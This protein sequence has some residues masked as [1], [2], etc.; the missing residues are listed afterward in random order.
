MPAYSA[1]ML[2]AAVWPAG[3]VFDGGKGLRHDLAEGFALGDAG[4]EFTG[5]GAELVVGQ[6][7][8]L[9]FELV[10]AR[11]DRAAFFDV[12]TVVPAGKFLKE[13]AEH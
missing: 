1:T 2:S 11:D 13:E 7:L 9:R 8:V 3:G 12:F 6:R 4:A 10:D 5:L